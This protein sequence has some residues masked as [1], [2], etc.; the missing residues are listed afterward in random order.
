MCDTTKYTLNII[1][2]VYNYIYEVTNTKI[3]FGVWSDLSERII[4]L[5][6]GSGMILPLAILYNRCTKMNI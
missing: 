2:K 3:R 5:S 6:Y 4:I 1:N